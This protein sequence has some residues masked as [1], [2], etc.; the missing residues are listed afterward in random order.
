MPK[1]N[2]FQLNKLQEILTASNING[3]LFRINLNNLNHVIYHIKPIL[4][5][6]LLH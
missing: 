5:A 2:K 1:V 4:P 6:V 3:K